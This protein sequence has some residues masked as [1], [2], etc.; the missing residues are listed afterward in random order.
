PQGW[1]YC[2]NVDPAIRAW[3]PTD[4]SAVASSDGDSGGPI[5]SY[6]NNFDLR[7]RGMIEGAEG[8]TVTCQSNPTGYGSRNCYH[9]AIFVGMGNINGTLN[10]APNHK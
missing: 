4:N 5:Y 7:A 2:F 9:K 3:D 10:I 1:G 6:D 8:S